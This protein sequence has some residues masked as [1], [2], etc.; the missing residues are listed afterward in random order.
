MNVP[1]LFSKSLFLKYTPFHKRDERVLL[2]FCI[3]VVSKS[4]KYSFCFG[5]CCTTLVFF[6]VIVSANVNAFTRTFELQE[7]IMLLTNEYTM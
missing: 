4:W 1:Q 7:K 3:S 2:S 5:R 6:L